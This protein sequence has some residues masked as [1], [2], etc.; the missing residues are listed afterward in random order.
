MIRVFALVGLMLIASTVT[1]ANNPSSQLSHVAGGALLA[2]AVTAIADK[3]WPDYDRA[4][5]GFTVSTVAGVLSQLYEYSDGTNDAN[6]A[7]LDA[8]SHALGSAIGAYVTHEYILMPVVKKEPSGGTYM[9]VNA[10]VKF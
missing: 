4:W 10:I 5:T 9:G 2:G 8:A 3:Y 7:L 1:A 6:D